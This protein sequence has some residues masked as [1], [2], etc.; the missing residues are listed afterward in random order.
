MLKKIIP[1]K[2]FV[3]KCPFEKPL[4][5]Q[6]SIYSLLGCDFL[7]GRLAAILCS[8]GEGYS[9]FNLFSS[10]LTLC[11]ECIGH[12]RVNK[13]YCIHIVFNLLVVNLDIIF[14]RKKKKPLAT[15]RI[16]PAKDTLILFSCFKKIEIEIEN[17]KIT[18]V[19]IYFALK[20]TFLRFLLY[21]TLHNNYITYG[22]LLFSCISC[23]DLFSVLGSAS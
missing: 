12:V 10:P 18:C 14:Y 3:A 8:C 11:V 5:Q 13:R 9:Y 21:N 20:I 4:L 16:F 17:E 2:R 19:P 6:G 1:K 23:S 15:R 7:R 22:W